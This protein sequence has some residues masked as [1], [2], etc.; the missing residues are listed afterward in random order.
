MLLESLLIS[1]K[2]L[3]IQFQQSYFNDLISKINI[4]SNIAII[5]KIVSSLIYLYRHRYV[6]YLQWQIIF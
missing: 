4:H 5:S 3:K 2:N 1:V 6:E